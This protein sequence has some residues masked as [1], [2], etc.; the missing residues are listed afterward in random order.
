MSTAAS[1]ALFPSFI[2]QYYFVS[3]DDSDVRISKSIL[4]DDWRLLLLICKYWLI[5]DFSNLER[6]S[7]VVRLKNDLINM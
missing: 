4:S 2:W 3:A 6:G 5:V 7:K 1:D